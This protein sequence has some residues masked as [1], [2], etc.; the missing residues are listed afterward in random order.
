MPKCRNTNSEVSVV[1]GN[2]NRKNRLMI[3]PWFDVNNESSLRTR[4]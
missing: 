1:S 2:V 3:N 4:K